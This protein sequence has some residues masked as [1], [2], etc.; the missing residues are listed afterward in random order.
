MRTKLLQDYYQ[1]KDYASLYKKRADIWNRCAN[2]PG[3]IQKMSLEVWKND[4]VEFIETFGWVII[5]EFNN[6]VKPLF[7]FPYQE[8]IIEKI[9][10]AE[11]SGEDHEILVD[12][13]RGMG[14][15]WILVWYQLW[16]WLFTENW[17]GFNLSRS[18][19]E[20]DNGTTDPGSSL[21]GKYRW[22]I[23][24][25]P[26]WMIPEG[27]VPK[28]K[29]GT[30]TD[31][32]LRISNPQIGS[33]LIG[34]STNQGAGRSRRYSM[35]FVDE[36][37]AIEHFQSVYRSLQ[38]V[39]RVKVFVSTVKAGR[40]YQDFK[41]MT[42]AAGN[43][44]SLTWKD[45]PFKDQIWYEEQIKKAEFDPEVMKEIE[46][47]Y[48]VNIKSQYYPEIR[49][50]KIVH[51]VQ[52]DRTKPLYV[53][54]DFGSQDS[55]V[56]VFCQF[57]GIE[58]IILEC[59]RNTRRNL[60]WYVPFLNPTVVEKPDHYTPY[61]RTRLKT[62]QSWSKPVAY[63]GEAAHFQKVMPLNR[64]IADELVKSGIRLICNNYAVKYEPRRHATSEMLSRT[65]F[66]F[67]SDGVTD[68]YDAIANSRYADAN[69]GTSKESH[70]KPV[71]DDV[72]SDYRSAF[73][74]LCVNVARIFRNQRKD[75]TVDNDTKQFA[76]NMIRFLKI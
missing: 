59:I 75:V 1:S 61:F 24:H 13:P 16:R 11:L 19:S 70:M 9:H 53:G 10:K 63:F 23:D 28:G 41:S 43:Y 5:P 3:F 62:I 45:H 38:S 58:M 49:N 31:M 27:F 73:E 22:G 32:M 20:V 18:E 8:R 48:S 47:D 56:L 21:F 40:I 60:D 72:I 69:R 15:T 14:L 6:A 26:Q 50:A 42:E 68:L 74:N 33:S 7:L 35:T 29:K 4:P 30:T 34:S 52:Y 12:K 51:D 57:N 44:I 71:H 37:F 36:C 64:S 2:E 66:N 54:M 46:V 17:G 67:S 55:T 25:L 65:V 39:S 76:N